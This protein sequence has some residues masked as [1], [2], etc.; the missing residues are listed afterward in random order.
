M[1][2]SR[3]PPEPDFER[4]RN[5]VC[6]IAVQRLGDRAL[7][8]DVANETI[9]RVIAAWREGRVINRDALRAF[10]MQVAEHVMCDERR[11]SLRVRL[12]DPAVLDQHADPAG[13]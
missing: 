6:I 7:A 5:G 8:E 2:D 4:L 12:S 1:P 9:A 10:V 11:L 13:V 3:D